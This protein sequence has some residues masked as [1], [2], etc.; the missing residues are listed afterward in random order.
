MV[1]LQDL[2]IM[3]KTECNLRLHWNRMTCSSESRHDS[4]HSPR[5]RENR[6]KRRDRCATRLRKS[7]PWSLYIFLRWICLALFKSTLKPVFRLWY[8]SY[9]ISFYQLDSEKHSTAQ[10]YLIAKCFLIVSKW[11][12]LKGVICFR[13]DVIFSYWCEVVFVVVIKLY[14]FGLWLELFNTFLS[15][16]CSKLQ[17][18]WIACLNLL[19]RE[20]S[21][22]EHFF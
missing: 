11:S 13:R 14:I 18:S 4:S 2:Q 7:R 6:A 8:Y 10:R 3:E 21:L 19:K 9:G 5:H 22:W 12:G 15:P 1:R 17:T 20:A 16:D